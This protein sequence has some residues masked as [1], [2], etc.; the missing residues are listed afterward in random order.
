MQDNH[1]LIFVNAMLENYGKPLDISLVDNNPYIHE[2]HINTTAG[3]E[4]KGNHL[5]ESSPNLPPTTN[6]KNL[7]RSKINTNERKI[8]PL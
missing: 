5:I 1:D 8:L 4:N 7:V 6:A 2:N 3:N